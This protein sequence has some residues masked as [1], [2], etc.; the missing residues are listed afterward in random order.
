MIPTGASDK[1]NESEVCHNLYSVIK[2]I[3]INKAKFKLDD[4]V[5]ISKYKR[6]F[7]KD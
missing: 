1:R 2:P 5:R 6:T 4:K 7:E 3:S